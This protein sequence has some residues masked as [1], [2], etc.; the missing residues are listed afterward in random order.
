MT[1]SKRRYLVCEVVSSMTWSGITWS[2]GC[3]TRTSAV[4]SFD[5]RVVRNLLNE[6]DV[7]AVVVFD[8]RF[9]TLVCWTD[10]IEDP[11]AFASWWLGSR[12]WW[13]PNDERRPAAPEGRDS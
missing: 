4:S 5:R 3:A 1:Q 2:V 10:H 13:V 8:R 9:G 12:K 7:G 6:G 11:R